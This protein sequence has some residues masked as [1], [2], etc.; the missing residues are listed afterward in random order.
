M[1]SVSA[2]IGALA[3]SMMTFIVYAV[4]ALLLA[5][6]LASGQITPRLIGLTFAAGR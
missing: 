3:A 5:V 6:Q 4:S 1:E 2:V